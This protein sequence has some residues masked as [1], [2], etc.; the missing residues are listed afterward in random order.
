MKDSRAVLPL[1]Y[2]AVPLSLSPTVKLE[3][4]ERMSD[5]VQERL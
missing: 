4:K 5:I 1:I 2:G 3:D